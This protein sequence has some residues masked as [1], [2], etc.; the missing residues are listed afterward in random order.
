MR[1]IRC[2]VQASQGPNTRRSWNSLL[3]HRSC[4]LRC[5]RERVWACLARE[6]LRPS[7]KRR[8]KPRQRPRRKPRP[9]E[10]QRWLCA[11]CSAVFP[12][13][14]FVF[15]SARGRAPGEARAGQAGY[16]RAGTLRTK[17]HVVSAKTA[18]TK[19]VTDA[20]SCLWKYRRGQARSDSLPLQ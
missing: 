14:F 13:L 16:C 1:E 8:R 12:L 2:R 9:E 7:R 3:S 15:S 10:F 4:R 19:G 17:K 20:Y 6:R 5:C 18:K 11:T